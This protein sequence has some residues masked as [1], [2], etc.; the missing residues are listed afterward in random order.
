LEVNQVS[1][2]NGCHRQTDT[3]RTNV[4]REQLCIEDHSSNIN[5]NAV[6][7]KKD[8][9]CRNTNTK[10]SFVGSSSRIGST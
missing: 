3:L 2:S 4:I 6:E 5:P 7:G 8:V 9:K 10:A 1:E